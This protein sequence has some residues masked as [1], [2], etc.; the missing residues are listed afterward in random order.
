MKIAL[1]ETEKRLVL[2]NIKK[3]PP[4]K[5]AYVAGVAAGLAMSEQPPQE[6]G[7]H[8]EEVKTP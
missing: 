4:E 1:S 2:E 3:L 8:K 5:Q 7:E 6:A